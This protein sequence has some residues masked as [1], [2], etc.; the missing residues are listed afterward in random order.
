MV[1]NHF[2]VF[3]SLHLFVLDL[4]GPA[5]P[6]EIEF[7]DGIVAFFEICSRFHN[8]SNNFGV[9]SN[10]DI[11]LVSLL[12]LYKSVFRLFRKGSWSGWLG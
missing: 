12:V 5:G 4:L 7:D 3:V 6:V 9:V 1:G 11:V 2:G 10:S 8:H